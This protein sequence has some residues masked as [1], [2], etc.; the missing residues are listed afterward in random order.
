MEETRKT[1]AKNFIR[2]YNTEEIQSLNF[3]FGKNNS[4]NWFTQ[5]ELSF[6]CDVDLLSKDSLE[7]ARNNWINMNFE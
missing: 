3:L 2:Y 6:A 1:K 4:N 7:D 5:E